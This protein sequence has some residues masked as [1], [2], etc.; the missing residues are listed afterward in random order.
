MPRRAETDFYGEYTVFERSELSAYRFTAR[1]VES[2]SSQGCNLCVRAA[3]PS[4]FVQVERYFRRRTGS[5]GAYGIL[6]RYPLA[7]SSRRLAALARGW[8]KKHRF[9]TSFDASERSSTGGRSHRR[10]IGSNFARR[11]AAVVRR[12]ITCC[13]SAADETQAAGTSQRGSSRARAP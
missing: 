7:T 1:H 10:R 4:N 13:C 8:E 2:A 6:V 12:A 3:T 11:L 9:Q 5:T